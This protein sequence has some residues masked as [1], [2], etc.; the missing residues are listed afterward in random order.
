VR[1]YTIVY[2]HL[3]PTQAKLDELDARCEMH[4]SSHTVELL[5]CSWTEL[6]SEERASQAFEG[7]RAIHSDA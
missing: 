6:A 4:S 7:L 5:T 2:G 3:T 1:D